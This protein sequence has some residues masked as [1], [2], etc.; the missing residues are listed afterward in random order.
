MRCKAIWRYSSSPDQPPEP[1]APV[2]Q[3]TRE[4]PHPIEPGAGNGHRVR[5]DDPHG[6]SERAAP[7]KPDRPLD[8]YDIAG[9]RPKQNDR[10]PAMA[11]HWYWCRRHQRAEHSGWAMDGC[12]RIGPF[13]SEAE[14]ERLSGIGGQNPA[15]GPLSMEVER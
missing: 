2:L 6:K 1:D 11:D 8:V 9:M 3:C 15:N 5:D 10:N 14:A 12:V 7:P 4:W 13:M